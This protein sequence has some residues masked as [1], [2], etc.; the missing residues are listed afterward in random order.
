MTG[1]LVDVAL[2]KALE[3]AEDWR[4]EAE[5][6]SGQLRVFAAVHMALLDEI[7]MAYVAL[8]SLPRNMAGDEHYLAVEMALHEAQ[9]IVAEIR[10]FRQVTP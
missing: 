9:K 4:R 6:V 10:P 5:S 1:P 7:E 2:S 3:D 8:V